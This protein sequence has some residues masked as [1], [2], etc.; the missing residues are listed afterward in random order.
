M[1]I[2]QIIDQELQDQD[3][4]NWSLFMNEDVDQTINTI[5]D[6]INYEVASNSTTKQ[7]YI[8][9]NQR[10]WITAEIKGLNDTKT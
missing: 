1:L 3:T 7:Y 5:I 9:N 10:P 6:Y 4:T 2:K 8:N